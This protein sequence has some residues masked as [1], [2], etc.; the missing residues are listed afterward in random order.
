M[1][2]KSALGK[3]WSVITCSPLFRNTST[4]DLSR[5]ISSVAFFALLLLIT[6]GLFAKIWQTNSRSDQVRRLMLSSDS[7]ILKKI[8]ASLEPDQ[9]RDFS[10]R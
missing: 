9:I 5:M 4:E 2:L 1:L 6:L 7:D 10:S 3:T 8:E